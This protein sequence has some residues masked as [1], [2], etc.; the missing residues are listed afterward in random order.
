MESFNN[1]TTEEK[2]ALEMLARLLNKSLVELILEITDEEIV[3]V[4]LVSAQ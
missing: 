4:Q 3:P 2:E 1:L